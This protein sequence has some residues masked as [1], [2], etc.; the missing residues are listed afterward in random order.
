MS[1]IVLFRV[2]ISLAHLIFGTLLVAVPMIN[3]KKLTYYLLRATLGT[4]SS[5]DTDEVYA[6]GD[7]CESERGEYESINFIPSLNYTS[8]DL[9][10]LLAVMF[11]VS[12]LFELLM[13][14]IY[15]KRHQEIIKNNENMTITWLEYGIT[16]GTA[17][18]IV[19]S[20]VGVQSIV[21]QTTLFVNTVRFYQVI[22]EISMKRIKEITTLIVLHLITWAYVIWFCIDS[23]MNSTIDQ[24]WYVYFI[25]ALVMITLNVP[26][27]IRIAKIINAITT[28]TETYTCLFLF[29]ASKLIISSL[30]FTPYI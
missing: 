3:T 25:L 13:G 29:N 10:I 20:L 22:P 24:P 17:V 15:G 4:C 26:I 9:K 18:S 16:A 30:V 14:T 19:S 7:Q 27:G 23:N 6:L 2:C 1:S 28:K 21:I 12:S 5:S 8:V 11:F